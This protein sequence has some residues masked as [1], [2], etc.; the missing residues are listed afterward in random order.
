MVIMYNTQGI[1]MQQ[2][3]KISE[4]LILFLLVLLKFT[5]YK[6]TH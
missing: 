5:Y 3:N 1:N 6:F 2:P 4:T